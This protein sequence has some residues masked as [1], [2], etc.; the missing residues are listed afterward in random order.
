MRWNCKDCCS[1]GAEGQRKA[2]ALHEPECTTG[3]IALQN[4]ENKDSVLRTSA[5]AQ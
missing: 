1:Q 4:K 5:Q 3:C 2:E